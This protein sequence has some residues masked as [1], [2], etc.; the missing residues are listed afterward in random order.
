M[1]KQLLFLALF[2]SVNS[3]NIA[4]N[5]VPNPSF[6]NYFNTFCGLMQSNDFSLTMMDWSN[7]T[8]GSPDVYFT[9]IDSTCYNFQPDSDYGGPIGL[10]GNQ[11][12][13]TGDVMVGIWLYTIDGFNQRDYIQIQLESDLVTGNAYVISFHVSLGDFMESSINN[14]GVHLSTTPVLSSDTEPLDVIPQIIDTSFIDEIDEWVLISDTII[15]DEDYRYL[16]IGNFYNDAN[17]MTQEN[18]S[19]SNEPGTYGAYY[20]VDDVSVEETILTSAKEVELSRFRLFPNP[21]SNSLKIEFSKS[22]GLN[23]LRVFNIKGDEVFR[24]NVGNQ[25]FIELDCTGFSNGTYIVQ[26]KN[27]KGVFN[28]KFVKL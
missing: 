28:Q 1:K 26:V 16:T 25:S 11:L 23:E 4:Q 19:A 3:Q 9:N 14:L 10:K 5:L 22:E 24:Q 8:S 17:T 6:E 27:E 12:P 21:V 2:F 13:K 7:P 20:F 15:A 18:P